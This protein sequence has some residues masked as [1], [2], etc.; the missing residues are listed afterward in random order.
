MA[1]KVKD[2]PAASSF[3]FEGACATFSCAMAGI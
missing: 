2:L 1:M 3:T